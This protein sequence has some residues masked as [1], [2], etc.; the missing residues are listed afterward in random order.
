MATLRTD[1]LG[2]VTC[3]VRMPRIEQRKGC[4]YLAGKEA[5]Q[6]LSSTQNETYL[7][8]VDKL[9]NEGD[10]VLQGNNWSD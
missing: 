3:K 6:I 10:K 9:N 5:Y 7:D 2:I 8:I 4:K 1:S